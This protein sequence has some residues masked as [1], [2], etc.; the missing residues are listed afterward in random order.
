VPQL[1]TAPLEPEPDDWR[2]LRS[3]CCCALTARAV[4][5]NTWFA[6]LGSIAAV[7]G[8]SRWM[9][10][11]KRA[12]ERWTTASPCNGGLEERTVVGRTS[13]GR[14]EEEVKSP[15]DAGGNA[16]LR[17]AARHTQS[18]DPGPSPHPPPLHILASS[19]APSRPFITVESY[20][21]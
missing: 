10:Y 12:E 20:R 15:T 6:T 1:T 21:F 17:L 11:R 16:S 9:Y 13:T 4:V 2:T 5:C 7:E 8:R 14:G 19:R 3:A 18:R